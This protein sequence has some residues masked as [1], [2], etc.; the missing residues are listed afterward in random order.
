MM[1][2][3]IFENLR[4]SEIIKENLAVLKEGRTWEQIALALYQILDDIDTMSDACKSN[5]QAFQDQVLR[6]QAE[7]NQYLYSPDGYTLQP[8]EPVDSETDGKTQTAAYPD[9]MLYNM[10]SPSNPPMERTDPNAEISDEGENEGDYEKGGYGS[11]LKSKHDISR[12]PPSKYPSSNNKPR[13]PEEADAVE[14]SL[15][16]HAERE[17]KLAGLFD[18]DSDYEGMLGEAVL[19]LMELFAKQDHSGFSAGMTTELFSRLAKFEALTELTNNSEEWI[20]IS[21]MQ[22]GEPG[23][24]SARSPSCFSTD[25]GKTY[26]NLDE[27]A[28]THEDE[29]GVSY[30]TYSGKKV[31]HT[32]K[33][34]K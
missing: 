30:Q 23:W 28:E 26:Y 10:S 6:L 20:D 16:A 5:L 22:G 4:R 7:K 8:S 19:E 18:K 3:E 24:Q 11:G 12:Y 9:L 2:N 1:I 32:S 21:E 27:L 14:E 34:Y 29:D 31:M 15:A 13:H 33:A 17:L 25:G